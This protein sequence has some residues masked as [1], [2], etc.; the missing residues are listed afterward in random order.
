MLVLL[1]VYSVDFFGLALDSFS[2]L[3]HVLVAH[4]AIFP[5]ISLNCD[6]ERCLAILMHVT[7]NAVGSG[8]EYLIPFL[9]RLIYTIMRN[10]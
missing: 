4:S 2:S 3:V 5:I 8:L 7:I 6:N 1:E 10:V 9:L